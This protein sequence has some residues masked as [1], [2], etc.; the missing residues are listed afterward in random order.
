MVRDTPELP[1]GPGG[2]MTRKKSVARPG[3]PWQQGQRNWY[4][5]P[6]PVWS[7]ATPDP[8]P[9]APTQE[10]LPA[11][12]TSGPDTGKPLSWPMP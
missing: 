8:S 3:P 10:M 4:A 2:A 12:S 11:E 5:V 6:D 9:G 1:P 7:V